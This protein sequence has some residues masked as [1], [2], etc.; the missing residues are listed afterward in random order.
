MSGELNPAAAIIAMC[1][2]I[3]RVAKVC[4]VDKKTVYRW[5]QAKGPRGGTGGT[6]PLDRARR[7]MEAFSKLTPEMFFGEIE[8]AN[9]ADSK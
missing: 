6:I 1:G 3:D 7:L 9:G 5:M 2:G 4:A 8:P